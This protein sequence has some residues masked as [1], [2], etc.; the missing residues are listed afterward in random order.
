MNFEVGARLHRKF[1]ASENASSRFC[2]LLAQGIIL[3]ICYLGCTYAHV[4]DPE[5][6]IY[7][8]Q[9]AQRFKDSN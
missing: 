6:H 5:I 9:I 2:V 1:G 3:Q 8:W 4:S 7:F